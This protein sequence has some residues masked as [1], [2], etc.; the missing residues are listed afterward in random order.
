MDAYNEQI[1]P[2]TKTL[3]EPQVREIGWLKYSW[4]WM[5]WKKEEEQVIQLSPEQ[6]CIEEGQKPRVYDVIVEKIFNSK[7][8]QIS[9]C[10]D[11]EELIQCMFVPYQRLVLHWIS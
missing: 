7:V 4:I 5:K 8:I 6:L 10:S 3:T 1:P 11:V 9:Q 2:D